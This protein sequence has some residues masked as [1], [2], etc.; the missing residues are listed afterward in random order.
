M[1]LFNEVAK[2]I[3]DGDSAKSVDLCLQL[4]DMGYDANE[5]IDEGLTQGMNM[6]SDLFE[7][8]EKFVP[9]ILM[10]A[11]SMN[12]CLAVLEPHVCG[13]SI[14]LNGTIV[15]GTV[16][17]DIHN[18]GK[19]LVA[20][21]FQAGCFN[22]VDIGTNVTKEE[23]IK[24]IRENDASIVALSAMLTTAMNNMKDIVKAINKIEFENPVYVMVGGA[25]ITA[26]YA[27]EIDAVFAED[28]ID[29][30]D[31]AIKLLRNRRI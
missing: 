25:P 29:A 27:K 16:E 18:I 28:A 5:I 2:S 8:E 19:G 11:R 23:F 24:A 31:K 10:S 1:N 3:L 17:G 20:L 30:R 15:I 22:V 26:R 12:A 4:L 13:K 14:P 21:M 6:L 9:Q 7:K